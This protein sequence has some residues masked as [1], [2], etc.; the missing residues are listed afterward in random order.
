MIEIGKLVLIGDT[1]KIED[2]ICKLL[3]GVAC[4]ITKIPINKS[5]T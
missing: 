1:R 5:E 2:K 3:I 4:K